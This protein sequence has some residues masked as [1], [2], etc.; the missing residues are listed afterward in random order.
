MINQTNSNLS[1]LPNSEIE[2]QKEA[3]GALDYDPTKD[4]RKNS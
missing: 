4:V 1:A 3:S 2:S